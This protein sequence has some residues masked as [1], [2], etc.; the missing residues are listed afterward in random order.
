M[1]DA[2]SPQQTAEA[3]IFDIGTAPDGADL[4]YLERVYWWAY[5]RP[6]SLRIFDHPAV[7]SAILWGQYRELCATA[8]AEIAPGERV[9]QMACV[10]GD[11]SP[12]GAASGTSGSAR[13]RGCGADSG[14][15]RQGQ[16]VRTALGDRA[17][18]R[19]SRDRSGTP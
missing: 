19:R 17:L 12:P 3:N 11:L 13:D 15:Q 5:F 6:A 1:F 16:A 4:D 2:Q 9:L 10:Y 18:R 7:V 14:R 8:I